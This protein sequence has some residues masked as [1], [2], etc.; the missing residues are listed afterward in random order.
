MQSD[1]SLM[2]RSGSIRLPVCGGPNNGPECPCSVWRRS[3]NIGSRTRSRS[4]AVNVVSSIRS[5]LDTIFEDSAIEL[6]KWLPAMWMM[7]NCKNGIS[8]YELARYRRH[9]EVGMV[10]AASDSRAIKDE[11][12]AQDRRRRWSCRGGRDFHRRQVPEHAQIARR[13]LKGNGMK[14]DGARR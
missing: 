14:A 10:H 5:R 12:A 8:S 11:S 13:R 2:N 9:S 3:G 1:T 7:A 4:S 6:D